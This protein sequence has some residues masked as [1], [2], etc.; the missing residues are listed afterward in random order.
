MALGV[1]LTC[2]LVSGVWSTVDNVESRNWQDDL[3]GASKFGDVFVQLKTKYSYKP[4]SNQLTGNPRWT[5]PALQ[6]AKETPKMA[7]APRVAKNKSLKIHSS[8]MLLHLFSVPSNSIIKLSMAFCSVTWNPLATNAGPS[9]SLML[10]TAV[11]TP[12][13]WWTALS[14]SRNSNA[15]CTPVEAPLGTAAR[16]IPLSVVRST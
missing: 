1:V 4:S 13:P 8:K 7:F 9:F 2:K 11:K 10:L 5:A 12:F 15:S 14:L 16:K 3:L 6:T